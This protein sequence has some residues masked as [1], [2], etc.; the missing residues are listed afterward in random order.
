MKYPWYE[1]SIE[2]IRISSGLLAGDESTTKI[3]YFF[4]NWYF[5]TLTICP[6]SFRPW[7]FCQLVLK[8]T[9][10]APNYT[11]RLIQSLIPWQIPNP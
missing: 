11:G 10:W 4:L 6:E 7:P 8:L 2:Q 5:L 9:G 1:S 3:C